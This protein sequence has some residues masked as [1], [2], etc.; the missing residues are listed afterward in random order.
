MLSILFS[1]FFIHKA[2]AA[3]VSFMLSLDIYDLWVETYTSNEFDIDLY[4]ALINDVGFSYYN[5]QY[6][7]QSIINNAHV[8]SSD[9][10]YLQAIITGFTN[11]PKP[12]LPLINILTQQLQEGVNIYL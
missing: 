3:T 7:L 9:K 1:G 8:G 5:Y 2:A 12:N 10:K 6:S 11:N 4:N